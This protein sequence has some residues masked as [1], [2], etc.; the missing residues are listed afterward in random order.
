MI[1]DGA[2]FKGSIHTVKPEP[3]KYSTSLQLMPQATPFAAAAP[4]N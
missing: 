1:E 2:Y 3:A 4:F